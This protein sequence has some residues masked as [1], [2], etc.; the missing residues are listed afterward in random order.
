MNQCDGT[1]FLCCQS[2]Q[3]FCHITRLAALLEFLSE[4]EKICRRNRPFPVFFSTGV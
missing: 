3:V 4:Y 2:V 1:I